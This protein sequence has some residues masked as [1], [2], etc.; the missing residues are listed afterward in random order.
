MQGLNLP[1]SLPCFMLDKLPL[2]LRRWRRCLLRLALAYGV[3][4]LT[5][6]HQVV[7]QPRL[8]EARIL[9]ARRERLE[10]RALELHRERPP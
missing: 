1:R 3:Q 7:Q 9:A 2:C 6:L 8:R 5:M 4:M 10:M